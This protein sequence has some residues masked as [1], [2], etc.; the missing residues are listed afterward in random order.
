MKKAILALAA[1]ALASCQTLTVNGVSITR[2]TQVLG[3]FGLILAGAALNYYAAGDGNDAKK[4]T[5][6]RAD[7]RGNCLEYYDG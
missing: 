3:L 2:E 5:C 1:L 4:R 7:D 6:L